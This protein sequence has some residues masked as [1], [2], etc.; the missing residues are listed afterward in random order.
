MGE[1][2]RISVD[3]ITEGSVYSE[4]V[5]FLDGKNM[6]LAANKKVKKYHIFAIKRWNIE[7]LF[8]AGRKLSEDQ[9]KKLFPENVEQQVTQKTPK[10]LQQP[11][12]EELEEI[13][14]LEELEE[15]E[16]V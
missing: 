16:E 14:E 13:D 11:V 8:T 7:N 3:E 15:L 6:F 4:P 2:R 12:V 1:M 10:K 5:F 9:V